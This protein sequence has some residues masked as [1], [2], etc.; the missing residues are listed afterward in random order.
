[1]IKKCL[2]LFCVLCVVQTKSDCADNF[3]KCFSDFAESFFH[4]ITE[5]EHVNA[6]T[7][8]IPED[9]KQVKDVE[10]KTLED[11]TDSIQD[12]FFKHLNSRVASDVVAVTDNPKTKIFVKTFSYSFGDSFLSGLENFKFNSD[13]YETEE[14]AEKVEQ[15]EKVDQTEKVNQTKNLQGNEKYETEQ[16][17]IEDRS[18]TTEQITDIINKENKNH[19]PII[20][21][22]GSA[23]IPAKSVNIDMKNNTQ[24]QN[25][26]E[27]TASALTTMHPNHNTQK[28]SEKE[29]KKD[30]P[31]KILQI[32][33]SNEH[34]STTNNTNNTN[35]E[36]KQLEDKSLARTVNPNHNKQKNLAV[37]QFEKD[38]RENLIQTDDEKYDY[39]IEETSDYPQIDYID[40]YKDTTNEENEYVPTVSPT[41]IDMNDEIVENVEEYSLEIETD[42]DIDNSVSCYKLN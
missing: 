24:E 16:F 1:M 28:L 9:Y 12:E 42:P 36:Q 21:N 40:L 8:N 7:E 26:T 15:V 35:Q 23:S 38:I 34:I 6:S 10:I 32:N 20:T 22:E 30:I 19:E 18:T 41:P 17:T 25:M 3:L 14:E 5:I 29:P 11:I 33:N 2:F 13:E 27:I 31:A 37:L 39:N 4:N